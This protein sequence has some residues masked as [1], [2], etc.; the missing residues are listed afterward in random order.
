M[1][2]HSEFR[3][4]TLI[5]C[6]FF[7]LSGCASSRVDFGQNELGYAKGHVTR[8]QILDAHAALN[9]DPDPPQMTDGVYSQNVFGVYRGLVADPGQRVKRT[10]N[11]IDP[12]IAP[13]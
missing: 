12:R 8:A 10:P 9:P 1:K 2:N 3:F 6:V 5:A 4:V 11:T 7:T 13:E